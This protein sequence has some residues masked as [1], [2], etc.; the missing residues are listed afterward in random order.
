MP[1]ETVHIGISKARALVL[2]EFLSRFMEDK[3]L[4]IQD[5]AEE[6]VL[7]DLQSDLE[8]VLKE[9]LLPNYR[10]LLEA[11]REKLRDKT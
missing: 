10:A 5:Q 4:I 2:Y 3:G 6:R 11:A 8:R 9:P 7:W 1:E